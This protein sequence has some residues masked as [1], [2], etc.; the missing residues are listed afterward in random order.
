MRVQWVYVDT[1][2]DTSSIEC[3][4]CHSIIDVGNDLDLITIHE[5]D[6]CGTKVQL[7]HT[8]A[9][10]TELYVEKEETNGKNGNKEVGEERSS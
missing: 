8:V 7:K 3:P 4:D 1:Y 9:H 10:L 5:C 6:D 2:V